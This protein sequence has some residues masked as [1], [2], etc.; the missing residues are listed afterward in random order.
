MTTRREFVLGIAGVGA[1]AATKKKP[2]F[3]PEKVLEIDEAGIVH[4]KGVIE[5]FVGEH[6]YFL[7]PGDSYSID[8]EATDQWE[9]S[10]K[11]TVIIEEIVPGDVAVEVQKK[12][13]DRGRMI[14]RKP[15]HGG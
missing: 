6:V 4:D 15:K 1:V 9:R 8:C 11:V 5:P 10:K 7:C 3:P 14:L 12:I 13:R 2:E